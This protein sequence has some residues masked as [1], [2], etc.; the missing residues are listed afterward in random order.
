MNGVL[1]IFTSRPRLLSV[2]PGRAQGVAMRAADSTYRIIGAAGASIVTVFGAVLTVVAVA[3][4]LATTFYSAGAAFAIG[5][6]YR[7][8]VALNEEIE[9]ARARVVEKEMAV[10]AARKDFSPEWERVLSATY[11]VP[12]TVARVATPWARALPHELSN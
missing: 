7:K 10:F 5:D 11:L 4:Y 6:G 2:I 9:K 12:D 8:I 3:A 1:T